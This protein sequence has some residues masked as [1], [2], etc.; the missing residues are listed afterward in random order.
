MIDDMDEKPD[1]FTQSLVAVWAITAIGVLEYLNLFYGKS[2]EWQFA[3]AVICIAGLGGF[4]A[5]V[6]IIKLRKGK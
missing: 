3:L 1:I 2:S 5:A 6:D 4:T